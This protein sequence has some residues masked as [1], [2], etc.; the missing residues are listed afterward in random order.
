ME[1]K[2]P[3]RNPDSSKNCFVM[4]RYRKNRKL[5]KVE[6][7]VI[8]A[9][10]KYGVEARLAKDRQDKPLLWAN[11]CAFMEHANF[12]IAIFDNVENY[13]VGEP[14]ANPNICMELGYMLAR[15]ADCLILRDTAGRPDVHGKLFT[16]LDGHIVQDIDTT[17]PMKDLGAIVS[18]WVQQRVRIAPIYDGFAQMFPHSKIARRIKEQPA[19]KLAIA[20]YL[21]GRWIERD[22]V[23]K[24]LLLD[25]GTT[26]AAVAEAIM[27]NA[28]AFAKTDIFTNNLLVSL[29]LSSVPGLRC[30]VLEG[31]V[32]D[33]YACVFMDPPRDAFP[34]K[35]IDTA[36]V[37]CTG[38]SID[39]GPLA[40]SQQNLQFKR[41]AMELC[42]RCFLVF[43]SEK[44]TATEGQPVFKS[45][46]DWTK[47]LQEKVA[48][49]I[50]DGKRNP[51]LV[52]AL[53]ENLE[54]ID[55]KA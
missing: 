26:A 24:S 39:H 18:K 11:V 49:V 28:E 9:L 41:A 34:E 7:T 22:E 29:M 20:R 38:F 43:G 30:H 2:S 16:D 32:D 12:G 50:T 15:G 14:R 31:V 3:F 25:S 6:T 44:A 40:N 47:T 4:M 52:A 8:Q 51:G 5:E 19:E 17:K 54:L 23:P 55:A 53:G 1:S 35:Q 42:S 13:Q 36:V 37:A 10:D 21:V 46:K 33:D 27:L 48:K 45:R